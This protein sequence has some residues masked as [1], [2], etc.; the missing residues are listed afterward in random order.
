MANELSIKAFVQFLESLPDLNIIPEAT[1]RNL[2]NSSLLLISSADLPEDE[3]VRTYAPD[4][5]LE[6]YIRNSESYPS[7]NTLQAYRSRLASA[8]R[9][10]VEHVTGEP[11]TATGKESGS[12]MLR[13]ASANF[14]KITHEELH[15]NLG[16]TTKKR[17]ASV[18]RKS[19]VKDKQDDEL[20]TFALPIPLR[21][22]LIL[23]IDNLPTDLS[24]DEAERIATIVKSF[25]VKN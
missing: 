4:R 13:N 24:I 8:V 7:E 2:K 5:Y 6:G 10:F 17:K 3:D 12:E 18:A 20:K 16:S 14:L 25:A 15:Q 11:L 9:L 19:S 22:D 1:A 23:T 21:S